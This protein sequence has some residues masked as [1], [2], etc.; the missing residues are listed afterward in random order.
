[1]DWGKLIESVAFPTVV[2]IAIG[3]F[4]VAKLWPFFVKQYEANQQLK[5]TEYE[6]GK[7][8]QADL[9]TARLNSFTESRNQFL[10]SLARRDAQ[11]G[12]FAKSLTT[13]TSSLVIAVEE[14]HKL[15]AESLARRDEQFARTLQER[16]NDFA[17]TL[18][19]RDNEIYKALV[20]IQAKQDSITQP[21]LARGA[22]RK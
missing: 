9:E 14:R 1:M 17:K 3:W 8:L 15:L 22:R 2:V 11:F 13:Q 6:A 18:Q 20:T 10:E 4:V 16:D 7:Q 12:D 19:E 5:S 21:S